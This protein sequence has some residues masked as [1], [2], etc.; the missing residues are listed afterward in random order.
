VFA[1]FVLVSAGQDRK[2]ITI[3]ITI[4]S[5]IEEVGEAPSLTLPEPTA[6]VACQTPNADTPLADTPTRFPWRAL[7]RPAD[8][9]LPP[10]FADPPI[11]FPAER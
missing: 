11:R 7:R 9:F 5:T 2:S 3:K 6:P 8:T 10:P 4:T 1:F